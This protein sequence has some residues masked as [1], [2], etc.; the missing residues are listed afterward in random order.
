M[1]EQPGYYYNIEHNGEVIA[2]ARM[3]SSLQNEL[4]MQESTGLRQLYTAIMLSIIEWCFVDDTEKPIP[5]SMDSLEYVIPEEYIR[6]MAESVFGK[7]KEWRENKEAI[8][9]N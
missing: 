1:K 9:K 2:K 5:V 6:I 4:W 7:I 3:L 8:L